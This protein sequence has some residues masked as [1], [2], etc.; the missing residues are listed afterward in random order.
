MSDIQRP[1]RPIQIGRSPGQAQTELAEASSL[2]KV[3]EARARF[4]VRGDGLTA[5]VL[6]TGINSK[7]VD[8]TGRIAA[9]VNLTADNGG[10][11]GD[12]TDGDGHGTNVCGIVAADGD[13]VG[14]APG[15]RLVPI[16]VLDN[17]GGG[18]F[19]TIAKGLTWVRDHH[20]EHGIT[21][22]SM[23][24]GDGSNQ[25]RDNDLLDD[26]IRTLIKELALLRIPVTV[27]A[28]NDFYRHDSRQGMGYPAI[29]RECISV[30]AVYDDDVGWMSYGDGA[31]AYTTAADRITP[32]SQRLH[33]S[34]SPDC[35]TRIFAPGAPIRSSGLPTATSDSGES[36][37]DGTSQATPVVAGVI[38]L[39]QQ[40]HRRVTGRLPEVADL[41]DW[42]QR[43][44]AS[45]FDGDDES[46][47]VDNSQ[48]S[49]RRVDALAAL[50]LL[51]RALEVRSLRAALGLRATVAGAR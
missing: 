21:V 33:P 1:R 2:I 3:F 13:H 10:Q 11:L 9:Q 27:A 17:D 51:N 30:G 47:N 45:I 34:V 35:Y 41:V 36:V 6:D 32:F 43:S 23:S 7:H 15:A 42:L 5:A 39:M 44:G 49:Y 29:V 26:P 19:A 24:L 48:L 20:A 14:M 8:F 12:A 4:S 18:S 16:K 38:L 25:V 37:Q 50:T 40:L 31:T 22:V 28:G 46:D